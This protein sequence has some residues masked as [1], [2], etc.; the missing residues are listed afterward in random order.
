MNYIEAIKERK[1]VRTFDK[2]KK[3]DEA[4]LN[5]IKEYIN[6]SSNPF[7]LKIEW[8]LLN[9]EEFNLSSPV[10]VGE[11]W[12]IGGKLKKEPL[13]ELAFGFEFEEIVL[14]LQTKNIGTTW[15]AGTLSR[16]IF[17]KAMDLN[18]DEVMPCVSPIGYK[19]NK[20][21]LR[22]KLMRKGIKAD[23]RLDFNEL[24]FSKDFKH[25]LNEEEL[26]K[27]K[28]I[29]ELVRIAPS[30]VNKQPWRILIDG[31]NIHFYKKASI[32]N[33]RGFDVQK[34]DMGIA[35]NHF[36]QG[37]KNKNLN[38]EFSFVDPNLESNDLEYIASIIVK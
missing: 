8:R 24:F 13:F 29:L 2:N 34:V 3:I 38:Y 9:C 36:I 12:Y 27:Y 20:L 31:N 16:D 11:N 14:F 4:L 17:E 33:D 15:M 5:E 6:N 19:A 25:S 28:D 18:D 7:N 37:L 21:S 30:A 10:I 23:S 35:M 32:K 26:N 1:S 22:E